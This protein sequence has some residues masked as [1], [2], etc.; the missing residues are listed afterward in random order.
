MIYFCINQRLDLIKYS[1]WGRRR[2][3]SKLIG[4]EVRGGPSDQGHQHI[5]SSI[6]SITIHVLPTSNFPCT[7]SLLMYL[8]MHSLKRP[9]P[10]QAVG[11]TKR[12]AWQQPASCEFCRLKKIRCDKQRP[13]SSCVARDTTCEYVTCK[14]SYNVVY[15]W[16]LTHAVAGGTLHPAVQ[17][18]VND[19]APATYIGTPSLERSALNNYVI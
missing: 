19:S 9:I 15:A 10:D 12:S 17:T 18:G 4:S 8:E 16:K 2:I 5:E 6:T 3:L 14:L 7:K 11:P 1:L 13:C